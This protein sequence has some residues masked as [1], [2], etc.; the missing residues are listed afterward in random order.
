MV[1]GGKK[2]YRNKRSRRNLKGGCGHGQM[3]LSPAPFLD[4]QNNTA[5]PVN[6]EQLNRYS[7]TQVGGNGYG[8]TSGA[9]ASTFKGNYIPLSQVQTDVIDKS[10]GGNNFMAGGARRSS[11]K[12][13]QRGC[14]SKRGG[15]KRSGSKK[16][17]GKKAKRSGS[18][19]R[20]SR[21]RKQKGGLILL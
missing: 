2:N 9:D 6:Y 8:Y 17:S 10:R 12:W 18:K 16:R 3:Q 19:K 20:S 21:T 14:Y 1:L 13:P 4:S 7:T 5:S 11:K 15:K